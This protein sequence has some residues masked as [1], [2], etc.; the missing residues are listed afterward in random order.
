MKKENIKEYEIGNHCFGEILRVNGVD[1]DGLK[2]EDIK[3]FIT[4]MI[5]NDINTIPLQREL[6]KITLEYL[7]LELT[8]SNHSKCEQCGDWNDYAKYELPDE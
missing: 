4:D 6:L 3:E 1:F 5:D 8:D 7:Q 2:K